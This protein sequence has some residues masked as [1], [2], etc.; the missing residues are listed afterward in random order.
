[1]QE[2][3]GRHLADLH[4]SIDQGIIIIPSQNHPNNDTPDVMKLV[5]KNTGWQTQIITFN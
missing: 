1:M 2:P 5:W 3:S 4:I